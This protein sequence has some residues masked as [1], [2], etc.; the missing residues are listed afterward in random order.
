MENTILTDLHCHTVAS[1]HAYSTIKEYAEIAAQ[2]GL[3][4]IAI[5]DHAPGVTDGAHIYHFQNL[6]SLPRVINN[7]TILRGAE[8]T[9]Q[10]SRAELDLDGNVLKNLDIVIASMH[11]SV[12]SPKDSDEHT[13]LLLCAMDNPYVDI[14]GHIGREKTEFDIEQ[15]V[16][17]AKKTKKL[18]EINS[19][20]LKGKRVWQHCARVALMCKKHDVPVVVTSDSHFCYDVGN[21]DSSLKLLSEAGFDMNLVMNSS[22]NKI[23]DFLKQKER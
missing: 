4:A 13:G 9:F 20:S 5:T 15:V 2:K 17:K 1:A 14:L 22:L 6:V 12:Y 10:N 23:T 7:V 18:I 19:S 3:E 8:C 21:F 16:L 11:Q